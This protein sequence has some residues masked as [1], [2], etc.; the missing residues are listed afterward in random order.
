[1]A[2]G[3][4]GLWC[5]DHS[6]CTLK[7]QDF[8]VEYGMLPECWGKWQHRRKTLGCTVE[9]WVEAQPFLVVSRKLIQRAEPY[10][11]APLG[12]PTAQP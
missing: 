6:H 7:T 9:I 4:N 10:Y 11:E 12:F 2:T 5:T 1:M 8:P 3:R